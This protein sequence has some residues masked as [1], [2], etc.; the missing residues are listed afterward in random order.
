LPTYFQSLEISSRC[1]MSEHAP[2]YDGKACSVTVLCEVQ[3]V[4]QAE[5]GIYQQGRIATYW[6]QRLS[7]V[8]GTLPERQQ[9]FYL[10]IFQLYDDVLQMR[11]TRRLTTAEIQGFL[12]WSLDPTQEPAAFEA[13]M[14]QFQEHLTREK[15]RLT[16]RGR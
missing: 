6:R 8:W 15:A 3:Y 11:S 9:R 13:N 16:R 10:A 5:S 2:S 7:P 1:N 12:R 4:A 14:R